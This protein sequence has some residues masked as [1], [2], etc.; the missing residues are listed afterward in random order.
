VKNHLLIRWS[1]EVRGDELCF[2]GHRGLM[3]WFQSCLGDSTL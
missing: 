2:L 3:M 1:N